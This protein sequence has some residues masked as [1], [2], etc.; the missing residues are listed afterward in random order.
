MVFFRIGGLQKPPADFD[1]RG[2]RLGRADQTGFGITPDFGQLIPV[3][4][5]LAAPWRLRSRRT[6]KRP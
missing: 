3:N 4:G 2:R 6:A 1:P 5:G